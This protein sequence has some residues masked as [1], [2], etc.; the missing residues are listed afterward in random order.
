M[1]DNFSTLISYLPR[2]DQTDWN[3]VTWVKIAS[4]ITGTVFVGVFL[5]FQKIKLPLSAARRVG[6]FYFWPSFPLLY[7]AAKVRGKGN[8]WVAIDDHVY[9]GAAP[10]AFLGHVDQLKK[11]G[12]RAV[13]NMCDEYS[14]P[15]REYRRKG[16]EQ[17]YLPTVDHCEP[18]VEDLTRAVAFIQQQKQKGASVY[19]HCR[20]GHGRGASVIMC[21]LLADKKFNLEEAQQY[22]STIR[23]VRSKLW[24]QKNINEF[25]FTYLNN[26][27]KS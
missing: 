7:I 22:L 8:W 20:A 21:W 14:G 18:S 15:E 12:V 6:R 17:L 11:M 1:S 10:F 24:R 9:L 19:V 4:A 5:L 13:V 26:N 27:P 25:Y 16:I 3:L 2:M 23:H